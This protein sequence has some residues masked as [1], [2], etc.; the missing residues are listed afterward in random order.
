MLSAH[1]Y[2]HTSLRTSVFVSKATQSQFHLHDSRACVSRQR[3]WLVACCF[4]PYSS[5]PHPEFL[6]PLSPESHSWPGP[7]GVTLCCSHKLEEIWELVSRGL[8]FS[9]PP[10]FL[11]ERGFLLVQSLFRDSVNKGTI[12]LEWITYVS[13]ARNLW[14][15]GKYSGFYSTRWIERTLRHWSRALS[16]LRLLATWRV[17]FLADVGT[18]K[19]SSYTR[20]MSS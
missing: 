3:W 20:K 6:L 10:F 14:K 19:T 2:I 18:S 9:Y 13:T 12:L 11:H 4:Y 17:W 5:I 16:S 8:F 1:T 15:G 7:D